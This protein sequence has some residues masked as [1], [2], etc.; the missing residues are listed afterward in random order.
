MKYKRKAIPKAIRL[1]VYEKCNGSC[2][3]CGEELTIKTV[4]IDHLH[5]MCR[6]IQSYN[7][8][9]S[10]DDFLNLMPACRQCNF[11]K[12]S[13]TLKQFRT[14]MKTLHERIMQP[15]ISRLGIKYSI[16]E[17]KPWDGIFYFE[18]LNGEEDGK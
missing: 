13:E 18:K 4:Q 6:P 9:K 14:S 10:H 1:K 2:A 11:Y 15:F 17:I 12:G 5:P 16:I 7:N 8:I 3:Y